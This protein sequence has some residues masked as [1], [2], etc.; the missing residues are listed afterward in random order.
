MFEILKSMVKEEWRVHSSI[1][2]SGMF[3][4]FPVLIALF[5]FGFSFFM[6]MFET[7]ISIKNIYTLIHYAG[8]LFGVS[9]G[10]FALFGREAMNRR[11]GQASMVAYSSRTLPVSER[12]IML[13]VV[14][15]DVIFYFMLYIIPFFVGFSFAGL[16]TPAVLAFSP[17][18]LATITLSFLVGMSVVFFLSTVYVHSGRFFVALM[19]VGGAFLLLLGN[20]VLN[21]DLVSALPPLEFFNSGSLAPLIYTILLII[22]PTALSMAFLRIEIPSSVRHVRNS[23]VRLSGLFGRLFDD[24][25]FL[26]KDWLDLQR[27]E[28]GIGKIFFSFIFPLVLIWAMLYIFSGLFSISLAAI[29]LAFSVLVGALSS[30]I[31][32][33]LTEY[34][35]FSSYAFLPVRVSDVIKGKLKGYLI[36]DLMSVA[37]IAGAAA[38]T[39]QLAY[40]PLGLFTF[41]IISAYSVSVTV[42]LAGL[43]PNVLIYSAKTFLSYTILIVP[44]LV[45]AIISSLINPVLIFIALPPFILFAYILLKKSSRKWDSKEQPTF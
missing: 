35:I 11:F 8:L 20:L 34:D 27:S 12:R 4:M 31:Y 13:N 6:P 33:W 15:N 2:G 9:I 22:V 19:V 36:L 28:G 10:A 39:G 40:L 14:A 7:I 43:S 24:S 41:A 3:A 30:S 38:L 21:I 37:I 25:H 18:L 45:L 32:N 17:L 1:F 26:A 44:C 5:T 23:L 42:F 29:F 16:F